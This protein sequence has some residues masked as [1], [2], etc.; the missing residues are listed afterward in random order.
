MVGTSSK[1][2][3][4]GYG[5]WLRMWGAALAPL[6]NDQPIQP[7]WSF[8][9]ITTNNSSSPET[10][11]R[12][13]EQESYGRQIGQ[14]MDVL[15]VLIDERGADA[16]PCEAIT[17][18]TALKTRIDTIKEK[19]AADYLERVRDDLKRLKTSDPKEFDRQMAKLR[20]I[21]N[22]AD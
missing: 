9:R 8:I 20:E 11:R 21:L 7:G 13:V 3:D 18:L 2:S 1:A 19:A 16:P 6:V 14:M 12:I 17:K 15:A 4:S 10:E 22:D 5:L